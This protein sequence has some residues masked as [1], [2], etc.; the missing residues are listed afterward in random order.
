MATKLTASPPRDDLIRSAARPG[1]RRIAARSGDGGDGS[2]LFGHFAVF[3]Q[4]TEIDS[5]WEGNFL[6]R[7]APG[8]FARTLAEDSIRVL[9]N[10]GRDPSVGDK[11]L[12]APVTLREDASGA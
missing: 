7:V 4:W 3:G 12:G 11:V 6:E 10:H 9:F 5:A 8:A 2:T 1:L